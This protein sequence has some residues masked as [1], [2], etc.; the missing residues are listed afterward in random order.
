MAVTAKHGVQF[1]NQLLFV[2]SYANLLNHYTEEG[3]NMS[4]LSLKFYHF[5][6]VASTIYTSLK[7]NVLFIFFLTLRC[8][9]KRII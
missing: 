3:K 4:F 6:L 7:S 5:A 8:I 1:P 9:A 2:S